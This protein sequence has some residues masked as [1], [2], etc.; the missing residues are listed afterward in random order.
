VPGLL[1]LRAKLKV[2]QSAGEVPRI[3]VTELSVRI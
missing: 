1:G 3:K 2:R